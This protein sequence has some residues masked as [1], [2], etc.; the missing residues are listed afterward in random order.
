MADALNVDS[1]GFGDFLVECTREC[2][3]RYCR[4]TPAQVTLRKKIVVDIC[5]RVSLV[6]EG[7]LDMDDRWCGE[8]LLK[9]EHSLDGAN[10]EK[11]DDLIICQEGHEH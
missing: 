3:S 2:N 8:G 10:G 9:L 7:A 6:W 5:S 4:M 11:K 1:C